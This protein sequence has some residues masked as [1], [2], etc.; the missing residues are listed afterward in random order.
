MEEKQRSNPKAKPSKKGGE[1]GATHAEKESAEDEELKRELEDV[2]KCV[3][4]GDPLLQAKSLETLSS[5]LHQTAGSLTSVPK[6]LKILRAFYSDLLEFCE[7]TMEDSE[8]RKLLYDILSYLA[9][10]MPASSSEKRKSLNLKLAGNISGLAQWGHEYVRHLSGEVAEECQMRLLDG[11]EGLDEL[12]ERIVDEIVPYYMTHNGEVDACDLLIDVERLDKIVAFCDESNFNKVGSYIVTAAAYVPEGED[13]PLLRAALDVYKGVQRFDEA[14]N[15]AFSLEQ[16]DIQDVFDSCDDPIMRKQLALICGD[17]HIVVDT[18]DDDLLDLTY[19]SS[20]SSRFVQ[21]A[22]D[23]DSLEP[24]TPEDIFKSHLI[25]SRRRTDQESPKMNLASTFVNGLVNCATK[26]DT[27]LLGETADEWLQKHNPDGC[28]SAVASIGL[29]HLW[30]TEEGPNLVDRYIEG[31]DKNFKAGGL[32]ATG[33]LQCGTRSSFNVALDLLQEHI[34]DPDQ[35][36]RIATIMG[37]GLAYAG[38]QNEQVMDLLNGVLLDENANIEVVSFSALAIG[39]VCAGSADGVLG[40]TMFSVM[41]VRSEDELKQACVRY[42]CLGI[43]LLYLQAGE[44]AEVAMETARASSPVISEYCLLTVMTCAYMGTGNVLK[45]QELLSVCGVH[46]KDKDKDADT[47]YQSV[48]VLGLAMVSMGE[49]VGK[50][51]SLRMLEQCLHYGD[52]AT[53][54]AIP[55]A[56]GLEFVSNPEIGVMETLSKLS[57]DVDKTVSMNAILSLGFIGAGTNHARIAQLLRQLSSYFA[58]S[59]EHQFVVRIAQGILFLGKGMLT[60]S[61]YH[62]DRRLLLPSAAAGLLIVM[63]SCLSTEETLFKKYD[64]LL[65]AFAC[66]IRPRFLSFVD[67]E[68]EPIKTTV[69]VGQAVDTVAQ[70]GKPR[71]ITGFQTH[72]S[73]VIL[74]HTDRAE[75]A[76]EE[77]IPLSS[78]L[79]GVVILKKNPEFKPQ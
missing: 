65:Y 46:H 22:G 76:T 36:V 70:A 32:L 33:I 45:M 24:K 31:S 69:R 21:V 41:L 10:T 1:K 79:E 17:H 4:E 55:L 19:R 66:A 42:L 9:T 49:S 68:L 75:L 34:S 72:T 15:V 40:E 43:G 25:D 13:A 62:R 59:K 37:L 51:M 56:M 64:F 35:K 63:H 30:D 6:P 39:L 52:V 44:A 61:P 38:T 77:Y 28:L 5:A 60:L 23:L 50:E 26:R 8:S 54:R 16:S 29:L 2:V 11:K 7:N 47:L 71:R 78:V 58:K 53:K 27:L 20:L 18:D 3:K 12:L 73:P 67:E 74:Q 48:A 57:H 14:L